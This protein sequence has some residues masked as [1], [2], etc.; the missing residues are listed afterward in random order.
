MENRSYLMVPFSR[1]WFCSST[2]G[3]TSYLSQQALG[4]LAGRREARQLENDLS[5][6]AGQ[7]LSPANS[8]QARLREAVAEVA[9]Q[10]TFALLST[11]LPE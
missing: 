1:L 11:Q 3:R 7:T 10:K 4:S 8:H 9:Q 2:G 6:V 5:S